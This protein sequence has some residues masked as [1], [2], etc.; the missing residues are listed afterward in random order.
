[1][2]IFLK[3]FPI[4]KWK[5][6]F[7]LT[8]V[9]SRFTYILSWQTLV[10][11]LSISF[12]AERI[13]L[14]LTTLVRCS[15]YILDQAQT[16]WFH[17]PLYQNS[18]QWGQRCNLVLSSKTPEEFS[19]GMLVKYLFSYKKGISDYD[20]NLFPQTSF[21]SPWMRCHKWK[22]APVLRSWGKSSENHRG[23]LIN[24]IHLW[25][26]TWCIYHLRFFL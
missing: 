5:W 9:I 12:F 25:A 15:E 3:F 7:F 11:W 8:S 20:T 16:L 26:N 14:S 10:E 2:W 24:I 19:W 1:M 18:S 4:L 21:L 23:P 17:F 22:W 6:I 13:I